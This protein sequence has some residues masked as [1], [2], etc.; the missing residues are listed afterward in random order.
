MTDKNGNVRI[1]EVH[2]SKGRAPSAAM[3]AYTAWKRSSRT[4]GSRQPT[5]GSEWQAAPQQWVTEVTARGRA[6]EAEA[7]SVKSI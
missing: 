2:A 7:R 6:Y 1:V 4:K 3:A 5:S